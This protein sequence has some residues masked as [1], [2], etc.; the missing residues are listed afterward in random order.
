MTLEIL[1]FPNDFLRIKATEVIKFDYELKT[2][3]ENLAETMYVAGGVGLAAT[4]VGDPRQIFVVDETG[5]GK[6]LTVFINPIILS[7]KGM[8]KSAEGCL[9]FPGKSSVVQRAKEIEVQAL[10]EAGQQFTINAS[11]LLSIIIQH[12]NDH[13]KGALMID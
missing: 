6:N 4:Q 12:E 3:I 11:G 10:N 5:E 1:K 2:F 7:K 13:L 8:I 9:S